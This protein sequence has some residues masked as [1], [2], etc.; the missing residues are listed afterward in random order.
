MI[1]KRATNSVDNIALRN[2]EGRGAAAAAEIAAA[3][4]DMAVGGGN[5]SAGQHVHSDRCVSGCI[6][7]CR[8]RGA[9]GPC[10]ATRG[11]NPAG[12]CR[13]H[14]GQATPERRPDPLGFGDPIHARVKVSEPSSRPAEPPNADDQP[15]EGGPADIDMGGTSPQ[16]RQQQQQ[17]QLLQQTQKQ[18]QE[19][20]Q[21]LP[22]MLMAQLVPQISQLLTQQLPQ[23][24][25]QLMPQIM[26]Q[27]EAATLQRVGAVKSEVEELQ[28]RVCSCAGDLHAVQQQMAELPPALRDLRQK[29]QEQDTA[30]AD[31]N[32][33]FNDL[34]LQLASLHKEVERL[35]S[36]RPANYATAAGGRQIGL[37]QGGSGQG[38][39]GGQGNVLGG[40][41]P[42]DKLWFSVEGL[43]G[44]N[45]ASSL[46]LGRIIQD[47]LLAK[48]TDA[49][50]EPL[51][52]IRVTSVKQFQVGP[53]GRRMKKIIFK[54]E[55]EMAATA[56]LKAR[57]SFHRAQG[58]VQGASGRIW[59][60]EYLTQVE[61]AHKKAL[62]AAYAREISEAR[63]KAT[64]EKRAMLSW[65]RDRLFLRVGEE[66]HERILQDLANKPETAGPP[67]E[68]RA[69]NSIRGGNQ[70][71]M[72]G[73]GGQRGRGGRGGT[74]RAEGG[75]LS[76]A[77]S[78]E[79][80]E[81]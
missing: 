1:A 49:R 48:L 42:D 30:T 52:D 43:P 7:T 28:R 34:E 81:I 51:P 59:V 32:L 25:Q 78:S 40:T 31:L 68:Q 39:G 46:Q 74:Q 26:T 4:D 44:A 24:V 50:G 33:R 71:S 67:A 18:T 29:A 54:V 60:N 5:R 53:E 3:G 13:S 56:I 79:G 41:S 47:K 22:S 69:P 77:G 20:L 38:S 19:Y 65:R 45:E 17:M 16:W 64:S 6:V 63:S 37:G 73:R 10:R 66:F 57:G 11:L 2:L 36:A 76:T 80:M 9:L 12:F 75:A 61:H 35:R 8:G 27:V 14:V 55:S 15:H 62:E 21:Q 70:P 23:L 58:E 72:R